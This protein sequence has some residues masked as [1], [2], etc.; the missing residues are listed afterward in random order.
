MTGTTEGNR[1]VTN[2]VITTIEI[3]APPG[4]MVEV[5]V[6]CATG[7]DERERVGRGRDLTAGHLVV[8]G[9]GEIVTIGDGVTVAAVVEAAVGATAVR[10]AEVVVAARMVSGIMMT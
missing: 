10:A 1:S 9:A 8:V 7:V 4:A 6:A 3:E 2:G 5:K